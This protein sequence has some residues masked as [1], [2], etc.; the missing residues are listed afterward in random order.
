M[1]TERTVSSLCNFPL[2][3]EHKSLVHVWYRVS[4]KFRTFR[5]HGIVNQRFLKC[6]LTLSKY[7]MYEFKIN[8]TITWSLK[9]KLHLTEWKEFKYLVRNFKSSRQKVSAASVTPWYWHLMFVKICPTVGSTASNE[10][11]FEICSLLIFVNTP[12]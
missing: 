3:F 8:V 2:M 12:P 10:E 7:K 1:C 11:Y 6:R 9:R 5:Y 4:N